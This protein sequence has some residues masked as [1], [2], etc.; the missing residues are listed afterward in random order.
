[1]SSRPEEAATLDLA[2][3]RAAA[4]ILSEAWASREVD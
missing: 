2:S 4:P 3:N 1:V